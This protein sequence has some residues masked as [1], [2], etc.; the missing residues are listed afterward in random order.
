[1][2]V[3][4]EVELKDGYSGIF[5]S[6]AQ[7][8]NVQKLVAIVP[9]IGTEKYVFTIV[10]NE[11]PNNVTIPITVTFYDVVGNYYVQ[12][13][14]IDKA[15]FMITT[16]K[17]TTIIQERIL[18]KVETITQTV[19]MTEIITSTII[20]SEALPIHMTVIPLAIIP[21]PIIVMLAI[22]LL[23]KKRRL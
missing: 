12:R 16:I 13:L 21:I 23:T 10:L 7:P 3:K 18:T 2:A 22:Y 11:T 5:L 4:A 8:A 20:G 19:S 15:T 6:Y 9:Y 1:V 17:I 14:F